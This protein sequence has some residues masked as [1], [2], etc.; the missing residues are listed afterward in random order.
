MKKIYVVI[1]LLLLMS[2][3]CLAMR[4]EQPIKIGSVKTAGDSGIAIE[5]ALS[6]NGTQKDNYYTKG[7]VQ[8][9]GNLYFHP[10]L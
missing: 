2:S 8:F 3:T 4:F 7:I 1:M 10:N 5:G 9:N 6:I